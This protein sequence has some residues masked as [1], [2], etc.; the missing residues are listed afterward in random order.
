M[1]QFTLCVYRRVVQEWQA[2]ASPAA[3]FPKGAIDIS[4]KRSLEVSKDIKRKVSDF[5]SL[6]NVWRR[7]WA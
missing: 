4:R 7:R 2:V 5:G 3:E 6:Y 1:T